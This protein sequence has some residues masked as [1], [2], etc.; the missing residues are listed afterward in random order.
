[1][2]EDYR[3]AVPPKP[4]D[5]VITYCP[6]CETQIKINDLA[7][8]PRESIYV[9]ST[10]GRHKASEARSIATCSVCGLLLQFNM[11]KLNKWLGI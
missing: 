11:A 7:Y 9:E 3:M 6:V 1:M 5:R 8:S 2:E 10:T 4:L